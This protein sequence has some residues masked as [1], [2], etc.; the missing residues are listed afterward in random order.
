MAAPLSAVLND[1]DA[2]TR[3]AAQDVRARL[4]AAVETS[5]PAQ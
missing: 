4:P 1:T 2:A 5:A 3:A